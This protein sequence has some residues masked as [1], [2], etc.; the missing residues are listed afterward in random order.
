MITR[1]HR[2]RVED[3]IRIGAEE[4]A[5]VKVGGGRPAHLDRGWYVE[6]TLF[7]D[8]TNDMRVAREE[9]FGPVAVVIPHDG[10]DDAIAIANDSPFG[11]SGTVW[12][13]DEDAA[14][15]V[16][17][18]VRTGTIALNTYTVDPDTPFGGYKES[19]IGREMGREGLDG[20]VELKSS[21]SPGRRWAEG[22]PLMS[23]HVVIV[24]AGSAGGVLAAR[25]SE[26]PDVSVL[27]LEAGPDYPSVEQMPE[28]IR[29]AWTFG[30][31]DH[32]WGYESAGVVATTAT[33]PRFGIETPG[34]VPV[35]RGKVVGGS[36]AVNGSNAMRAY[37]SD[38]DRWVGLGNDEW[39]WEAVLPYFRRAEDDAAGGDWHGTGGPVPIRRFTGE[40]LR[41]VMRAFLDG[42]AQAG[43]EIVE[44]LN[45]PGA[46]GAGSLPVNQVDGVRQSTAIAYL[47]PARRR[48]NLEIRAGVTV[49]R[50][51][52]IDGR[53]RAVVLT[54]G[55]RIDADVI[56]LAA[57]A[58]GSPT[59]PA[60]LRHRAG[61]QLE[62]LGIA[63]VH[64]LEG[65]GRNLRDHPMLY[66]TWTTD[67]DA[68]GALTPPLQAFLAC[69]A[70]GAHVQD[71]IDLN[72]VPFTLQPGAILVGMGLVRPYSIGHLEL[73][74]ADPDVA[75]RIFLN[76][77]DHP[78][79]LQRMVTGVKII[80]SIVGSAAMQRYVGDELWP[81]PDVTSDAAIAAAILGTP[82]TYAHV[83]GTCAMGQAGADWAVVD[84]R[85]KVHGL[86]GL[87]VIDA[88]IMPTIPAVP[89]NMTTIMIAERCADALRASLA[90]TAAA[91]A[92]A[93]PTMA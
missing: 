73:A 65:V 31:M 75:P 86:E 1:A 90:A 92:V 27:L 37:R 21:R 40:S 70:S 11:L 69:S 74:A 20:Y 93:A 33:E 38:F 67:T 39:S 10:V 57:G 81:G 9:I 85:G 79:D 28:D 87:H 2:D 60:A 54:S 71:Q 25:L 29:S 8:V 51:E 44:D 59:H 26:D 82:T 46:V 63:L 66:P 45:A 30:G 35:P 42:C 56:V 50:V 4:G 52:L 47:A 16:A 55:E 32:D 5:T 36:S 24:G 53:A 91:P 89:T 14:L 68:V 3:Y 34:V 15:A 43:H 84:Q 18:R 13:E 80:R 76:L 19:G 6:P 48:P 58:I 72:F 78:E 49:D 61:R 64:H 83:V 22:G 23:R 88:S 12:T 62:R 7:A 17:R 41:P 77:F